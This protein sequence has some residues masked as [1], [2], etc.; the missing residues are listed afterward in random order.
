MKVIFLGSPASVLKP[1]EF[2]LMPSS[3]INLIAV[4]SQPAK[5]V[6]RSKELVDP[7]V[8]QFAKQR[9]IPVYQPGRAD[10]QNFL[11]SLGLLQPDL[12]IT[13][14]YGQ[15]LTEDF[16]AIPTRGTINIH[17]SLIP[18]YRGA[19]PVP[20]AILAGDK[21]TGVTILFTVR[22]LDAGNI[23]V[24]E[25]TAIGDRERGDDLTARL[26]S[27]STKLLPKALAH[28]ENIDFTGVAQLE[29]DV[30]ICKKISKDDGLIAWTSSS[31]EIFNRF[32]AF[33]PWPGSSTFFGDKRIS[34]EAMDLANAELPLLAPGTFEYSKP[35]KALVVGTGTGNLILTQLKPA[36]SRTQDAASFWNGIKLKDH[37]QFG[38]PNG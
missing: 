9:G 8:A 28:L 38:G 37:V 25:R 21:E 16:L 26:F 4:V 24:Q 33:S 1:L 11:E 10:D 20:A 7:P 17:P 18:K 12:M 30:T 19:T 22:K 3:G 32:R 29:K 35:A 23:I 5:A 34:I 31:V 6:G 15:I 2:L 27:L 14:A 36:G 13:A